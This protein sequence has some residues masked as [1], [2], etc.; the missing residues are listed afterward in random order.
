MKFSTIIYFIMWTPVLI[1]MYDIS[2]ED[3]G[4]AKLLSKLNT[5]TEII[6]P[7]TS[8]ILLTDKEA[9]YC[10]NESI[11][12]SII[13]DKPLDDIIIGYFN[14]ATNDFN[15]RCEQFRIASSELDDLRKEAEGNRKALD[16]QAHE[17]V[18]AWQKIALLPPV[19]LEETN[20]ISI[21]FQRLDPSNTDDA[22]IIQERLKELGYFE[23]NI[24]GIW[25]NQSRDALK[26]F[27]QHNSMAL[28]S[29]WDTVTQ[30]LLFRTR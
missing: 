4:L 17:R 20:P 16:K 5:P 6:P 13:K 2:P 3:V 10:I 24:D 14:L 1:M 12:L 26:S 28:N 15:R 21:G 18:A 23:Y 19:N 22:R 7:P 29:D 9:R 30:L 27:K 25:G 8:D 11:R